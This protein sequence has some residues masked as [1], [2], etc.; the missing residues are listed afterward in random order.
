MNIYKKFKQSSFLW[1]LGLAVGNKFKMNFCQ[2]ILNSDRV[3]KEAQSK[4]NIIAAIK[5]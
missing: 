1:E 4:K 3:N 2:Q 5:H